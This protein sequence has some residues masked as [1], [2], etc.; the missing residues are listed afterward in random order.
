MSVK[1]FINCGELLLALGDEGR[2]YGHVFIARTDPGGVRHSITFSNMLLN[3]CAHHCKERMHVSAQDL[4]RVRAGKLNQARLFFH[5]ELHQNILSAVG[6]GSR[7][8]YSSAFFPEFPGEGIFGASTIDVGRTEGW[9]D[10]RLN[11]KIERGDQEE[12]PPASGYPGVL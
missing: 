1:L 5:G 3:D 6:Y 10:V 2:C 9:L 11:S 12:S 4:K 8:R 7:T